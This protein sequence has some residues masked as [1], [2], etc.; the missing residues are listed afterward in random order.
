MNNAIIAKRVTIEEDNT[1]LAVKLALELRIQELE[2][3]QKA[4]KDAEEQLKQQVALSLK[5]QSLKLYEGEFVHVPEYDLTY[6]YVNEDFW[7]M[8]FPITEVL[9][10]I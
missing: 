7:P 8:N 2:T 5:T 3:A 1:L 4:V 10:P 6:Y 9:L